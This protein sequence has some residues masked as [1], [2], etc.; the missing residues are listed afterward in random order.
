MEKEKDYPFKK[1]GNFL[2]QHDVVFCNLECPVTCEEKSKK[3]LAFRCEP[4]FFDEFVKAGFNL[5]SIAN[6]HIFDCGVKGVEDTIKYLENYGIVFSGALNDE[7]KFAIIE[8]NGIK[9]AILAF[10]YQPFM[11]EFY[12]N[13]RNKN[14]NDKLIIDAIKR[15]KNI[16]DFVFVSFHW[17]VEYSNIPAE[18]QK[19]IARKCVDAGADMVLGHH[20]HV[21]QPIEKYKDKF[22][23]Y[24]FG[25][26]IFDQFKKET[27][28]SFVFSCFLT[29]KKEIKDAFIVPVVINFCQPIYAENKIADKIIGN[30]IKYSGGYG[31]EFEKEQNKLFIK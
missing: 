25:N 9:I 30:I 16:A 2:R 13:F 27:K 12:K 22:I 7:N 24:S 17:G 8:K 20:P 6:N 15:C 4:E 21:I 11:L 23:F 28:Y 26:F 18:Y 10:V 29:D 19:T 1:V 31:V 14:I 3:T 5:I